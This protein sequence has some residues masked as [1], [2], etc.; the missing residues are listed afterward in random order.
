MKPPLVLLLDGS[1]L[2]TQLLRLHV[3]AHLDE[4][5]DLQPK[6]DCGLGWDH[7][8]AEQLLAHLIHLDVLHLEILLP[9]KFDEVLRRSI[10]F[11][12]L[13]CHLLFSPLLLPPTTPSMRPVSLLLALL[14]LAS[15]PPSS[16]SVEVDPDISLKVPLLTSNSFDTTTAR[17]MWFVMFFAPWCG[18]CKHLKP[19]FAELADAPELRLGQ[20]LSLAAVDCTK[21][22]ALCERHGATSYPTLRF[23]VDSVMYDYKGL[24]GLQPFREFARRLLQ[25]ETTRLTDARALQKFT[26]PKGRLVNFVWH[27]PHD[28]ADDTEQEVM[29][30]VQLRATGYGG[31]R[32][33]VTRS[34]P[35]PGAQGLALV[36]FNDVLHLP[37]EGP[38]T[39]GAIGDWVEANR[40]LMVEDLDETT[41]YAMGHRGKSLAILICSAHDYT[42]YG[43]GRPDLQEVSATPLRE[44]FVFGRLDGSAQAEWVAGFGIGTSQYPYLLVYDAVIETYFRN[45]SHAALIKAAMQAANGHAGSLIAELLQ[46]VAQGQERETALGLRGHLNRVT[47]DYFPFML[48]HLQEMQVALLLCPILILTLLGVLAFFCFD[49]EAP[50]TK[51]VA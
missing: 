17:G 4:L 18:H 24:R 19:V 9:S 27:V 12:P 11:R 44:K 37:Y 16:P 10:F 35:V 49:S 6:V 50:V 43:F 15:L 40:F 51:K 23:F 33:G 3:F 28:P 46:R 25:P 5:I 34:V 20:R 21:E 39:V 41:F 36:A 42:N 38:W 29:D 8:P 45:D 14:S 13:L 31:I 47:R 26:D 22:K 32:F 1:Q 7:L 30:K 48:G 2:R